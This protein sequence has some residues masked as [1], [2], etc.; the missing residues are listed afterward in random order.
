MRREN[1]ARETGHGI[2]V[3]GKAHVPGVA[4]DEYSASGI[5]EFAYVLAHGWLAQSE[6]DAGV[7]E[8]ARI[9]NGEEGSQQDGIKHRAPHY[10]YQ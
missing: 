2:P 10:V 5:L 6:L 1:R 8:A 7:G 4:R 9:R 3:V